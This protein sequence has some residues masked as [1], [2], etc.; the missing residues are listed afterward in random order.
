MSYREERCAEK[1][2][3]NILTGNQVKSNYE[4][5][6]SPVA[7]ARGCSAIERLTGAEKAYKQKLKNLSIGRLAETNYW[8]TRFNR[9]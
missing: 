7:V 1:S 4:K 8:G 2:L 9:M 3:G 5:P 6:A